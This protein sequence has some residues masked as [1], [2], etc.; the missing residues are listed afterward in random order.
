MK[1][2]L[3][4]FALC[5]VRL[6]AQPSPLPQIYYVT[7]APAGGCTVAQPLGLQIVIS[8]GDQWYC[9]GTTIGGAGT[10]TL[11][12]TG[13]GGGAPTGPAGGVLSGTYPNPGLATSVAIPGSPTTTTQTTGDG[14]TKVSTDAFVANAL[15]AINPATNVQVSTT[16]VLPNTPAYNN[17]TGGVGATLTAGSNTTLAAIDG[18]TVQLNDRILVQNQVATANDGVYTL[19]A[20]GSGGAPWVLTRA[21]DYNTVT[22]I[23][24]TGFICTIQVGSMYA[25]DTC[26]SLTALISSVGA[27]SI[28]YTQQAAGANSGKAGGGVQFTGNTTPG[29]VVVVASGASGKNVK[30]YGFPPGELAVN[31]P[32]PGSTCTFS[33]GATVCVCTT[34]C[35]ITVPVPAAGYQFCAM[36]DDNVSTVIT[37]SAIGSS[38][39]YENQARTAYGTATTGT[40]VS[41][42]AV[43]D[44]ACILGRDSTHYLF[45]S[46]GGTWTA[47]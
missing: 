27:S 15:Q 29:D 13:G 41:G 4:L 38:G 10:W 17:G 16:T 2:L 32:T 20:T 12:S 24:Y 11:G 9:K 34:T 33:G 35:T 30:D 40:L 1:R 43:K 3:L 31:L 36:N 45:A 5:G 7:V 42:G 19:T 23:N 28:T 14:T 8:T 21:A 44:F 46:G 26:F 25:A 47:N 6:F 39:R 37:M 18:Y 22:N